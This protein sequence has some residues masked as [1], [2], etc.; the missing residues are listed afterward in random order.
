MHTA[1]LTS[2]HLEGKWLGSMTS[3]MLD[4]LHAACCSKMSA[5]LDKFSLLKTSSVVFKGVTD[6]ATAGDKE[7]TT[8]ASVTSVTT[9][10]YEGAEILL[11]FLLFC[12]SLILT[13]WE[14]LLTVNIVV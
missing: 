10:S 1:M 14:N 6:K 13:I 9:S 12:C 2:M 5:W 7:I 3:C 8:T 11:F 4:Y